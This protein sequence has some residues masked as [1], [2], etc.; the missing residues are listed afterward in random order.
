VF[1]DSHSTYDV[2]W[3]S[4]RIHSLQ[5]ALLITSPTLL[6]VA[7]IIAA[8]GLRTANRDVEKMED[9]WAARPALAVP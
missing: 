4:D 1:G 8:T 6:I 7:A 3:I 2:G 9:E 5:G